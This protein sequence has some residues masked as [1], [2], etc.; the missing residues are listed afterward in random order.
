MTVSKARRIFPGILNYSPKIFRKP[1]VFPYIFRPSLVYNSSTNV[2]DKRNGGY[3]SG[4]GREA[5]SVTR[6]P[7]RSG[8]NGE[9]DHLSGL[10]LLLI[11]STLGTKVGKGGI[12]VLSKLAEE[13][14]RRAEASVWRTGYF[15]YCCLVY[16]AN[17]RCQ[18]CVPELQ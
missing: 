10:F 12:I 6:S 4:G 16:M 5:A 17:L 2:C 7:G 18:D 8:V 1:L 13:N 11:N 14:E 15:L 9:T 3:K